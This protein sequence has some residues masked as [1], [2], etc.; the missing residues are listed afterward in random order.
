[1]TVAAADGVREVPG[2]RAAWR[3]WPCS[4]TAARARRGEPGR[5]ARARGRPP[6]RPRARLARARPL[7]PA[8]PP[9]HDP[10]RPQEHP[11]TLLEIA[12]R[13]AAPP[14][15]PDAFAGRFAP[16]TR[17]SSGSAT[18][19]LPGPAHDAG[20]RVRPARRRARAWRSP[21]R[22]T[23]VPIADVRAPHRPRLAST[24]PWSRG[25]ARRARG[26]RDGGEARAGPV[27]ADLGGVGGRWL[28]EILDHLRAME[29]VDRAAPS[30]STSWSRLEEPLG[31]HGAPVGSSTWSSSSPSYVAVSEFDDSTATYRGRR[32]RRYRLLQGLENRTVEVGCDLWRVSRVAQ[33]SPDV[34]AV[35]GDVGGR[36]RARRGCEV[37]RRPRAAGRARRAHLRARAP[38]RAVGPDEPTFREDP[39]PVRQDAAGLRRAARRGEPGHRA[40]AP[41]PRARGGGRRRPPASGATRPRSSPASRR[42]LEAAQIG[43]AAHRGPR[44]PHRLARRQPRPRASSPS[45]AGSSTEG[46]LDDRDDVLHADP[47]GAARRRAGRA[48]GR[49]P[50]ARRRPQGRARRHAR[51]AAA[52]LGTPRRARRPP[53]P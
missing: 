19:A 40:R 7:P 9:D 33:R 47:R 4:T 22:G 50:R 49:P 25:R 52:R 18:A 10:P 8:V 21:S 42:L 11:M 28:P 6:G 41:G 35:L 48:A 51:H 27:L 14:Q 53:T 15:P 17:P 46:V 38:R 30:R 24:R 29:A 2:S 39:A 32:L 13:P 12:R 34:M 45:V 3:A 36:R 23:A 1:M 43:L 20:V 31:A 5:R 26:E 37:A 44:L 16:A